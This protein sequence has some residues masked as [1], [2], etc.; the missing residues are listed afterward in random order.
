M[1]YGFIAAVQFSSVTQS[2]PT[3]SDP[4]DCSPPGFPALCYLPEFAQ[5]Y[6]HCVS[7]AIRP[8]HPLLSPSPPAFNLPQY[9]GLNE[10]ALRIRWPKYWR[11][12]FSISPSN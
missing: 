7:D 12:S 6:V 5:T 9:Q 3:L 11:F 10:L 2:C 1:I 8:S 4:M